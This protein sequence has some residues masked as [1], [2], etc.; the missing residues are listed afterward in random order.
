MTSYEWYWPKVSGTIGRR[1]VVSLLADSNAIPLRCPVPT[2]SACDS[3]TIKLSA[4]HPVHHTASVANVDQ[5]RAVYCRG[6]KG[7]LCRTLATADLTTKLTTIHLMHLTA[8]M[9]NFDWRRQVCFR[10]TK[11]GVLCRTSTMADLE[12]RWRRHYRRAYQFNLQLT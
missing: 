2:Y 8:F 7:V 6:V 10:E 12:E 3:L 1:R 4:I 11:L 9:A 5:I